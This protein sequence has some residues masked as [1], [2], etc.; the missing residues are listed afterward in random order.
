MWCQ[1]SLETCEVLRVCVRLFALRFLPPMVVLYYWE[2]L[3]ERWTCFMNRLTSERV[4]TAQ[5][6]NRTSQQLPLTH[7]NEQRLVHAGLYQGLEPENVQLKKSLRE[8]KE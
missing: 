5:D 8:V 3:G 6:T 4:R 1:F 7:D 2:A